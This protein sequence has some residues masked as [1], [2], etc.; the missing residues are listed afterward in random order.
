MTDVDADPDPGAGD[1]SRRF[2]R[3]AAAGLIATVVMSIL[4]IAGYAVGPRPLGEPL[5]FGLLA[6]LVASVLHETPTSAPAIAV[7]IPLHFAYGALWA[8][9]AAIATRHMTWRRGL[10]VGLGMWLIMAIFLLPLAGTA[11]FAVATKATIWI[12]TL[13]LHAVYGATFGALVDHP[14]FAHARST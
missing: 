13:V 6:R 8:G 3:G 10:V 12:V 11:T 9:C 7:A 14:Q 5:P 1:D 4:M 2:W